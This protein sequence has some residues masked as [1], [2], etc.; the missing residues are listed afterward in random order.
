MKKNKSTRDLWIPASWR[1]TGAGVYKNKKKTLDRKKKYKE[2]DY[3][4]SSDWK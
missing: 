1:Y 2:K 3:E 4:S